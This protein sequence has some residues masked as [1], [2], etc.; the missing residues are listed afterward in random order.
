MK[1][2]NADNFLKKRHVE[3]WMTKWH[4]QL[5]LMMKVSI[6]RVPRQCPESE[7]EM[8]SWSINSARSLHLCGGCAVLGWAAVCRNCLIF[9]QSC[10]C[11]ALPCPGW[12]HFLSAAQLWHCQDITDING[13][14]QQKLVRGW[15]GAN[16]TVC[17]G[18]DGLLEG[19]YEHSLVATGPCRLH[20]LFCLDSCLNSYSKKLKYL[21]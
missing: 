17:A 3:Y 9:T 20:F 19:T 16:C 10:L 2:V 11:P 6:F 5:M 13:E 7:S 4:D 15:Q 1:K 18:R 21:W 12:L 14:D 8:N